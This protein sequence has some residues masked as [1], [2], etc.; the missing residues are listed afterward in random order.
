MATSLLAVVS[1]FDGLVGA[2]A[3]D[4]L[5]SPSIQTSWS[6]LTPFRPLRSPV[7]TG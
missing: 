4:H 6:G 7:A 1:K 2:E 5:H 3:S